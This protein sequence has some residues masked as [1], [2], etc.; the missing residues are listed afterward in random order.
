MIAWFIGNNFNGAPLDSNISKVEYY[1]IGMKSINA[2]ARAAGKDFFQTANLRQKHTGTAV[3]VDN[4]TFCN[5][6]ADG[7]VATNPELLLCIRTADCAPILLRDN[8]NKVIGA[9]HA[10]WRGALNGVIENTVNL[11]IEHGADVR[12]I[13]AFTGPMMQKESF[14]VRQDMIDL[15]IEKDKKFNCFFSQSIPNTG[16]KS[17]FFFKDFL[18]YKLGAVCKIQNTNFSKINTY[19]DEKWHSYRRAAHQKL[20]HVGLNMSVISL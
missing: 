6:E 11:M 5:I 1:P 13:N 4:F 14:E 7:M 18:R 12:H 8:I 20:G 2:V 9:I 19:T 15:F 17:Y 10:G 16:E 3:F